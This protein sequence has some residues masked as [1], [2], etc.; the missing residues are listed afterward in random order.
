LTLPDF[1]IIGAARCGTTSLYFDLVK[2][3]QILPNR[4]WK[5]INYFDLR[6][7]DYSPSWYGDR[8]PA[9]EEGSKLITGEATVN[10]LHDLEC[11]KRIY[12]TV[13]NVK[14]IATLRNPIDRAISHYFLFLDSWKKGRRHV[15]LDGNIPWKEWK[16]DKSLDEVIDDE[17]EGRISNRHLKI[18]NKG[19]YAE[20]LKEYYKYFPKKQ[21][22]I[23]QSEKYFE[24][25]IKVYADL[26]E[27]LEISPFKPVK[28]EHRN[29]YIHDDKNDTGKGI[30]PV[31][32]ETRQRLIEYF[33]PFNQELY[34]LL[35]YEMEGWDK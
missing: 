14:L 4:V 29:P 34:K 33:K 28:F 25:P 13:P 15:I 5:E 7:K 19:R 21:L 31:K 1:I 32:I 30:Y 20:Q 24:T 18:L 3:P 16:E 9:I 22:F 2:H 10:Y 17:I 23:I 6:W 11:A 35:G 12:S 27:F 8:F 26:L